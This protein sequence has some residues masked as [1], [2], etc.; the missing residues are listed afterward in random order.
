M[1]ERMSTGAG[2]CGTVILWTVTG[3]L[4]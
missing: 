1:N 3:M 4:W 2:I